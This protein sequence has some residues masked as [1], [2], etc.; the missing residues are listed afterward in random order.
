MK[1]SW[2]PLTMQ[3]QE[4]KWKAEQA[5]EAE[6]KKL[7]ELRQQLADERAREEM[8]TMAVDAGLKK[9]SDRLEWMYKGTHNIN[10]DEYLLGKRIDKQVDNVLQAA[11]REKEALSSGPG[12]LFVPTDS[13]VSVDL[14]AKIREDP[15]FAI[16]KREEE[17]KKAL[18]NNPVKL[19]QLKKALEI[20]TDKKKKKKS[21]TKSLPRHT[22]KDRSRSPPRHTH[23]D[24]SRSP[25]RHTHKDRSR[26]PPRHTHRDR[27]RSPPRHTHRDRSR[28]PPRHTHKDRSRSPPRHTHR[29]RSRSPPRHTHK[30]RSRSPPR[31]THRDRSRSP[32]RHTHR[33]RSRS[34]PRHTHRDRSRSPPRHTHRDRSRSPPRHT[35]SDRSRSPPRHTH[36]D[37]SRSPPRHTHRDRSRSPPRRTD[38]STFSRTKLDKSDLERR[39]Q[40]MMSNAVWRESEREARLKRATEE[41][42]IEK[43]MSTKNPEFLQ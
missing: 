16:R 32:P 5:N 27:S 39:R 31:H 9:R 23:K 11:D 43:N 18:L 22:H 19:S 6:K 28:S 33:D 40:E 35:H 14:A 7:E 38:K 2:H 20:T 37:R 26:S 34:P 21:K 25:P 29:D 13:D 1:K 8:E 10:R 15:L 4:R 41:E 12:A 3:N 30:D 36:R 24:R 17:R 42:Q